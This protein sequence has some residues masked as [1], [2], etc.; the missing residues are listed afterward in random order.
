MATFNT[1]N[2]SFYYLRERLYIKV[3]VI[4]YGNGSVLFKI[5]HKQTRYWLIYDKHEWKF[6]ADIQP[7]RRLKDI[8]IKK[9]VSH[10]DL[11]LNPST[12]RLV[13]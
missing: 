7:C 2:I 6:I 5:R 11:T 10:S 9:I 4:Y 3:F 12:M 13:I 8:I 1:F